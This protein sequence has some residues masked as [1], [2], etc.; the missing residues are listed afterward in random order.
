LSHLD[1]RV[2]ICGVCS[3]EDARA[4]VAAGA[5]AIGLNFHA[6]SPRHVTP[7][8]AAEIARAAR[9]VAPRAPAVVGVFVNEPIASMKRI[10]ESVGLDVLQI[11]GDEPPTYLAEL[12]RAVTLPVM[13][14]FR[15]GP[16]GLQRVFDY[17]AQCRRL[18]CPPR[19][20][21]LDSHR[22]GSYGGTGTTADWSLAAQFP[23]GGEQPRL[24]LAGG[25]NPQNAAGAIAAVKPDA[26]D[27]AS[28]VETAPRSKDPVRVRE[29]VNAAKRAFGLM[30]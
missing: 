24:V 18:G 7:E 25:L 14:A 29:F 15:L 23:R 20:V 5:D 17:L 6:E 11:H 30:P 21:L 8:A 10:A 28:G 26:V 19:W 9:E 1:F 27:T 4:A 2:K 13:R 16:E 22:S 12:G 3:A